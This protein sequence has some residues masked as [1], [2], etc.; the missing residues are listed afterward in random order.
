MDGYSALRWVFKG[1]LKLGFGLAVT[2]EEHIPT[3][4]PV[5]LAVNRGS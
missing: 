4:G 3:S 1:I 5:V 2:G